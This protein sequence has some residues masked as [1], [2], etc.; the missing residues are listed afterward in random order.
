MERR[1]SFG[2]MSGEEGH[3]RSGWGEAKGF[4]ERGYGGLNS[5]SRCVRADTSAD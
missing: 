1:G 4:R 5:G 2:S 3:R